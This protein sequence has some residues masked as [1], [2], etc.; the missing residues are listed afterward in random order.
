MSTHRS[1]FRTEALRRYRESFEQSAPPRFSRPSRIAWLW[2][3]IIVCVLGGAAGAFAR[4]EIY[5]PG[6]LVAVD[7]QS[8]S[9]TIL[10]PARAL[11]QL[12]PGQAI[13]LQHPSG[14]RL[15][16]G[17]IA[18]I[19]PQV[20]SIEEASSRFGFKIF[21]FSGPSEPV[22]IATAAPPAGTPN[23]PVADET[24]NWRQVQVE[25]GSRRIGAF[26]PGIGSWYE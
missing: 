20:F 17:L 8:A 24:W 4:I 15:T 1:I 23:L 18:E 26:L 10:I 6:Y 7:R 14:T 11:P 9:R 25:I 5:A 19:E 13:S 2:G 22:V 21:A 16:I 12:R 3:L